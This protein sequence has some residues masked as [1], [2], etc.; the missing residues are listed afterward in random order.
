MRDTGKGILAQDIPKLFTRF[1]KLHRTAKTND[2]GIGLGLKIVSMIIEACSGSVSVKSDGPGKGSC[3]TLMIPMTPL[4][5][6]SVVAETS[7]HDESLNEIFPRPSQLSCS[8]D[9][10]Q[11][12][13]ERN[14]VQNVVDQSQGLQSLL[15]ASPSR[16]EL[17]VI[18]LTSP[19][20]QNQHLIDTGSG[21]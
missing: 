16:N 15:L 13:T 21:P 5:S 8:Q 10:S 1:G 18:P 9:I 17:S 7:L 20:V 6:A 4:S 2:E 11:D 3:F 12:N 19:E 14:L